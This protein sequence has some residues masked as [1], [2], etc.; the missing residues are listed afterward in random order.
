[1]LRSLRSRSALAVAAALIAAAA[2]PFV[3]Q[4]R[5]ALAP[6]VHEQHNWRQSDVY[7]VA[8]S[9]HE[10][11]FDFFHPRIDFWRGPTGIVGMEAPVYPTL[12]HL[13]MF[14]VGEHPRAARLVSVAAF[15]LAILLAARL[16]GPE[17]SSAGARRL[18][19]V[20]LFTFALLSPMGLCEFRQIQPDGF[21]V[22][23]TLAS[24]ALF[25]FHARTGRRRWLALG[26]ALYA[27]AVIT[28]SPV[29]VAG[30]TLFL[31]AHGWR[32]PEARRTA[33]IA[34][35]FM[36]P[37]VVGVAWFSWAGALTRRYEVLNPYF[38]LSF[39][40]NE[41]RGNLENGALRMHMLGLFGIYVSGW[42]LVPAI[43]AGLLLGFRAEE[44]SIA[45]PMLL[46]LAA[47]VF[48]CLAFAYRATVHPYYSM[49]VFPPVAYFGGLGLSNL[50]EVGTSPARSGRLERIAAVFLVLAFGATLWAGGPAATGQ[51]VPGA[52]GAVYERT[53]FSVPKL[54]VLALF[55]GLA[56]ALGLFLRPGWVE[57]HVPIG[58]A[59]VVLACAIAL[60]RAVHDATNAF[61]YRTS[62]SEWSTFD[63][64]IAEM[65]AAVRRVSTRADLFIVDGYNPWYLH[66]T[67]RRG[68]SVDSGTF[69][70]LGAN[71]YLSRGARFYLHHIETD[72][73]AAL[74][75]DR[76][77]I[78]KGETFELYC[79]DPV[80]TRC[81][82]VETAQ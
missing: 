32:R 38:N 26:L 66:L 37:I 15:F 2:A 78:L 47:G 17:A 40:L 55:G 22:S 5:S 54:E 9:F 67:R 64:R 14:F 18:R 56:F 31:L 81:P 46:W 33:L 20:G 45:I 69:A 60:P 75:A 35:A 59:L 39:D 24:A 77:P 16:L 79:V 27:L 57:R 48:F 28:K 58:H 52:D 12:A 82:K 36:L 44:R 43:L 63:A 76:T 61:E 3:L 62:S 72:P 42:A 71:W 70:A 25:V 1:M 73:L 7:S 29:L 10:D 13:A 8:Y 50:A 30:P 41:I 53:W 23:A 21:A 11:G 68:F 80:G 19:A 4:V 6:I 51:G 34:L 74:I 49:V 65:Q